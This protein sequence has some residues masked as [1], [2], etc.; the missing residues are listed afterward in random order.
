MSGTLAASTTV[1]G[2][3]INGIGVV[4]IATQ[5]VLARRQ[6]QDNTDLSTNEALRVKRQATIDF[7]MNTMQRVNEWRSLLPDEWDQPAVEAYINKAYGHSHGGKGKLGILAGYLQ[8]FEAL[9]VAVRSG[10]YD[11]TV[12]DSIAGSRIINICE[13]YQSFFDKRRVEV[14]TGKAYEHLEWLG[15]E[16]RKHRAEMELQVR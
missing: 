14:G 4:F 11:L 8:Y 9:A 2:L 3:A 10:I 6:L 1:I 13:N 7:Y 5:V 16:I 12:L 15:D